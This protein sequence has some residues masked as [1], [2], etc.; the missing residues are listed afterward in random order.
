[1]M[2]EQLQ[3]FREFSGD[4]QH[5]GSLVLNEEKASFTYA[6][7]YLDARNAQ[8]ISLCL[9]LQEVPFSPEVT[10]TFFEGLLPEGDFRR[11]L[12]WTLHLGVDS[13]SKMLARLNNESTGALIFW[14]GEPSDNS[15]LL[16]NRSYE[17]FTS[18]NLERFS[19]QPRSVA[20]ETGMASRLSL[21]GAQAK[22][23]LY[24]QGNDPADGWFLPLGSA[25]STHIVKASDGTFPHQTVNEALCLATARYLGFDTAESFLISASGAEPMLA[26]KRFDRI[27]VE[28]APVSNGLSIP[29]RLHQEDFCQAAGLP[30][31]MKYEPTDGRYL[32]LAAHAIARSVENPFGDR[33]VFFSRVLFDFF[34]GN[35]DNHLKNH[36]FLWSASWRS[37]ELSPLYDITCTT[38]YPELAKEMG[39]S[40]SPSRR[41][42]GVTKSDIL[43]S[44]ASVNIDEKL[45]WL[46]YEELREDFLPAL[47]KAEL[48]LINHGYQEASLI[49]DFIRKD[50]IKRLPQ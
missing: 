34:I 29:R 8:G 38:F 33:M 9:P 26:I 13:Y 22:L 43:A 41:V 44:A 4:Y 40:L 14:L 2:S 24:H 25:P 31:F 12:A 30:S 46:Y 39:V 1:M 36:S 49:A 35:C 15:S 48:E 7:S 28:N 21:A 20:L 11:A 3:V 50:F 17:F 19:K 32:N 27:V 37:R 5:I 23:G 45:A 47:E 18:E 6:E 10:R 16:E 42:D